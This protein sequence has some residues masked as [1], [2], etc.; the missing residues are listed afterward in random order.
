MLA[1]MSDMEGADVN[2]V[3]DDSPNIRMQNMHKN[4]KYASMCFSTK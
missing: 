4:A 2:Y 1:L 3:F